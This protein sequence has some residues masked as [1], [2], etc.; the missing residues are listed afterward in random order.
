MQMTYPNVGYKRLHIH[1][2]VKV[3]AAMEGSSHDNEK[4][5][6]QK[7]WDNYLCFLGQYLKDLFCDFTVFPIIKKHTY[8]H[9]GS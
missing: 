7:I 4:S 9:M 1:L 5:L 8:V 3:A 2:S 6:L